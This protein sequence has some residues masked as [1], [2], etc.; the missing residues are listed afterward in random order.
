MNSI[1]YVS[2]LNTHSVLDLFLNYR[3]IISWDYK[4]WR[5]YF[6]IRLDGTKINGGNEASCWYPGVYLIKY[7]SRVLSSTASVILPPFCSCLITIW[8][9]QVL[10]SPFIFV[11][12]ERNS[13]VYFQMSEISCY[14][15]WFLSFH[16]IFLWGIKLFLW[17]VRV[18]NFDFPDVPVQ[19]LTITFLH[20]KKI[21]TYFT[22]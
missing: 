22:I 18:W 1:I 4:W 17:L 13:K 6:K 5:K 3:S 19:G 14:L 16:E 8:C 20:V 12:S 15:T 21:A 11:P 9:C 7:D 10:F 2:Q